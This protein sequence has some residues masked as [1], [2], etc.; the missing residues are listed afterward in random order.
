MIWLLGILPQ[1]RLEHN[2]RVNYLDETEEMNGPSLSSKRQEDHEPRAQ[3]DHK[4]KFWGERIKTMEYN[5]VDL[6]LGRAVLC[7]KSFKDT[8]TQR[9]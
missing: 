6:S 5:Q 7:V 3:N 4:Q 1:G 8:V 2:L 9:N